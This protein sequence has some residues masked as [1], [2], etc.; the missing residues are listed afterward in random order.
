MEATVWRAHLVIHHT[1]TAP[2]QGPFSQRPNDRKTGSLRAHQK[3]K[4]T[5]VSFQTVPIHLLHILRECLDVSLK[6]QHRAKPLQPPKDIRIGPWPRRR[7]SLVGHAGP[8]PEPL[9]HAVEAL[10]PIRGPSLE[11]MMCA[12]PPRVEREGGAYRGS[13]DGKDEACEQTFEQMH[14]RGLGHGLG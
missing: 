4:K 13:R 10:A 1:K 7:W 6:T 11:H 14:L 2:W 8:A 12:R 3:K 5:Y 9:A